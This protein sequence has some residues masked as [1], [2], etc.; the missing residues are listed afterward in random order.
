MACGV[1]KLVVEFS[2]AT[3]CALVLEAGKTV[4]IKRVEAVHMPVGVTTLTATVA[5]TLTYSTSER[6]SEFFRSPA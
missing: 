6:R 3:L 5:P 2:P 1:E 4:Q